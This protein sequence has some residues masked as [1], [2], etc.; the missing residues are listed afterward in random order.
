[1][2]I[3][4]SFLFLVVRPLLLVAMPGAPVASAILVST[5]STPSG[6]TPSGRWRR[7][8]GAGPVRGVTPQNSGWAPGKN[9]FEQRDLKTSQSLVTRALLVARSKRAWC[10]ELPKKDPYEWGVPNQLAAR[11]P[12]ICNTAAHSGLHGRPQSFIFIASSIFS[13]SFLVRLDFLFV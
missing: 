12:I 2:L 5:G 7:D 13:V 11:D 1:M 8:A 9:R 4:T 3:P 6:P 10:F